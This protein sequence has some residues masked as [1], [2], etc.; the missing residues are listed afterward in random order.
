VWVVQGWVQGL[1]LQA[2]YS[3]LE[4]VSRKQAGYG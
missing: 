1:A 2:D 3:Q 4:R